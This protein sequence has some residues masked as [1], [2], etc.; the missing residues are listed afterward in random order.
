MT[1]EPSLPNIKF[2]PAYAAVD[3]CA[4]YL[5]GLGIGI[6]PKLTALIFAIRNLATT[7]FYHISTFTMNYKDLDSH[8]AFLAGSIISNMIFLVTLREMNIIGK[9]SSYALVAVFLGSI[10]HRVTYIQLKEREMIYGIKGL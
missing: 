8:K 10:I 2:I 7:L 6:N 1:N 9:L 4:G 5:L 3:L